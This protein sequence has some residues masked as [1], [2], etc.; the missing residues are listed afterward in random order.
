MLDLYLDGT[1]HQISSFD[2]VVDRLDGVT[3]SFIKELTRRALMAALDAGVAID[4]AILD[5]SIDELLERSVPIT[6]RSLGIGDTE[7]DGPPMGD[8]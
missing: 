8:W 2:S 3:A 5:D 1:G 7:M 4:E 6:Q